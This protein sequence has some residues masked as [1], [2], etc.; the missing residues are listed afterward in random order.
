[1]IDQAKHATE[2]RMKSRGKEWKF[3]GK[4]EKRAPAVP[5]SFTTWVDV[6][7]ILTFESN[8]ILTVSKTG[9][10]VLN[11]HNSY[12]PGTMAAMNGVLSV[13]G[14]TLSGTPGDCTDWYVSNNKSWSQWDVC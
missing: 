6:D 2:R 9:L 7:F 5:P 14:I 13:F 8:D 1:M 10:I 12:S 11:S 3:K 4:R